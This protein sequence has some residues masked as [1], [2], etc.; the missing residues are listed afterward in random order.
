MKLFPQQYRVQ[1]GDTLGSIAY[2]FTGNTNR[3]V[4]LVMANPQLPTTVVNRQITFLNNIYPGQLLNIPYDWGSSTGVAQ[5]TVRVEPRVAYANAQLL[6]S[7]GGGGRAGGHGGAGGSHGSMRGMGDLFRAGLGDP[8]S[9]GTAA[10]LVA[11]FNADN[12]VTV[13]TGSPIVNGIRQPN[14]AVLAFQQSYNGST[15]GQKLDEDGL[16][17]PNC[18]TALANTLAAAGSSLQAPGDCTNF[19]APSPVLSTAPDLNFIANEVAGDFTLCNGYNANV[20]A[21]QDAYNAKTGSTLGQTQDYGFYTE[22]TAAAMLDTANVTLQ[23]GLTAPAACPFP[24]PAGPGSI[25]TPGGAVTP[26]PPPP[27][28]IPPT[29]PTQP[30]STTATTTTNYTPWIIGALAVLAGAGGLYYMNRHKHT[31]SSSPTL[32]PSSHPAA[33]PAVHRML[34]RGGHQVRRAGHAVAHHARAAAHRARAAI[35]HA[36]R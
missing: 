7:G 12:G 32:G 5:P 9:D 3:Y 24:E 30:T 35:H 19:T 11:A 8:M 23:S 6:R 36:T 31:A 33:T 1:P 28:F 34:A 16:Y 10:A 15:T 21:F 17:G 26:P 27:P 25:S 18:A 20:A 22:P 14:A 29:Q 13:C 4:E 2:K